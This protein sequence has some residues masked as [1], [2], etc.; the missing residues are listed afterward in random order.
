MDFQKAEQLKAQYQT[1]KQVSANLT[2]CAK[3]SSELVDKSKQEMLEYLWEAIS[4]EIRDSMLPVLKGAKSF[5]SLGSDEKIS[6]NF[7]CRSDGEYIEAA[8]DSK[9][10]ASIR[11]LLGKIGAPWC[12]EAA[13]P[14]WS[15]PSPCGKL[16][17]S[18]RWSIVHNYKEGTQKEHLYSFTFH[19]PLG[20][21]SLLKQWIDDHGLEVDWTKTRKPWAETVDS[22]SKQAEEEYRQAANKMQFWNLLENR[23]MPELDYPL[24]DM[25]AATVLWETCGFGT[26]NIIVP[27]EA[28]MC[29]PVSMGEY[30][31]KIPVE[32]S[33]EEAGI[34]MDAW[35][36]RLDKPWRFAMEKW[37]LD[38]QHLKG[39]SR[40]VVPLLGNGPLYKF[41]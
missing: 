16:K 30:H 7:M 11:K 5:A 27:F 8:Y 22:L 1:V 23:S 36:Q 41:S 13:K 38:N 34:F 21:F 24:T 26:D 3:S 32:L 17:M 10:S 29:E 18:W 19:V 25:E 6:L 15:I 40:A 37:C 12:I 14:W 28:T 4:Q 20:E 35:K 31:R 2:E 39:E 33:E 9:P